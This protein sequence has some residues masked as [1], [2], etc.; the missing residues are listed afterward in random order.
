MAGRQSPREGRGVPDDET[1]SD[2]ER[3][4]AASYIAYQRARTAPEEADALLVLGRSFNER[5]LYRPAPIVSGRGSPQFNPETASMDD[6][7]K[8]WAERRTKAGLR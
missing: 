7:A 8:H 3:A 4:T 6:Y 1:G 2:H 5:K